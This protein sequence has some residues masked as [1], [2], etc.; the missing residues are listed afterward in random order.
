[1]EETYTFQEMYGHTGNFTTFSEI[2]YFFPLNFL[3]QRDYDIA[4]F[5]RSK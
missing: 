5:M 4:M 3:F 2:I 1:M